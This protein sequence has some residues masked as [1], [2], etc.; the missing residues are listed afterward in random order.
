MPMCQECKQEFTEKQKQ[1]RRQIFCSSRCRLR[2]W[3]KNNPE[4]C[5]KSG[6]KYRNKIR[7]INPK[8]CHVCGDLLGKGKSVIC[9]KLE[10]KKEILK[11]TQ[12]KYRFERRLEV[13][14]LLGGPICANCGC[15]DISALEINHIHGGGA[16]EFR[17]GQGTRLV[18]EIFFGKRDPKNF[19]VTCRV[20]NALHYMGLK[21][22]NGWKVIWKDKKMAENGDV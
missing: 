11:I 19:E 20:C 18:D 15:D 4:K 1:T 7:R 8:Y 9:G 6:E 14:K 2:N 5:K 16:K 21:G 13:M 10:C 17:E 12:K 3:Q 22:L